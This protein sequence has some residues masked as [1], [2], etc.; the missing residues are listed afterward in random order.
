MGAQSAV[1]VVLNRA[2][3]ILIEILFGLRSGTRFLSGIE[4]LV[5]LLGT[6]W[7]ILAGLLVIAL[8]M[9]V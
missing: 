5:G 7:C 2:L 8:G 6:L 9:F 1:G 3:R 4:H